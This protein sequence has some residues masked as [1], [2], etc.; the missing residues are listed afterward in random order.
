MIGG[1]DD[2]SIRLNHSWGSAKRLGCDFEVQGDVKLAK[3]IIKRTMAG[4]KWQLS[5]AVDT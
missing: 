2:R 5:A 3:D 4:A 1:S